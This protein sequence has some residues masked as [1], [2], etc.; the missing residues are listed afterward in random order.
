V[1]ALGIALLA[2]SPAR[3]SQSPPPSL[4]DLIDKATRQGTLRVIVEVLPE[5]SAPYSREAIA[6]AQDLV[7]QELSGT[8][9]RVLRRYATIPFLGLAASADAL[10][11]LGGSLYVGSIREDT[12]LRPQGSPASP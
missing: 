7:V 5:G 10:R 2:P 4:D 3:A 9:H 12:L 8:S 1:L 11:R 6:K